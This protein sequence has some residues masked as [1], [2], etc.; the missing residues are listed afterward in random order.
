MACLYAIETVNGTVY[1]AGDAIVAISPK[2]ENTCSLKLVGGVEYD[3]L[4]PAHQLADELVESDY[5]I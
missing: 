2:T 1:V 5:E 3:C 4:L